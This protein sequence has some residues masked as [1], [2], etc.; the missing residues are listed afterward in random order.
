MV[1]VFT[2][3]KNQTEA[4]KIGLALLKKRLAACI[5]VIPKIYSAYFWPPQRGKIEKTKEAVLLVKTLKNKFSAAEREIKRLHSYAVP[6]I[7]EI[8]ILRIHRPYFAW[9]KREV[10]DKVQ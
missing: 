6:I 9:L 4:E 2:T 8:P 10:K 7:A 3:C 5:I 1:I